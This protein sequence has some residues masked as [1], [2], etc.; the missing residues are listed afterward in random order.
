[1]NRKIDRVVVLLNRVDE[2]PAP[3]LN[4][5]PWTTCRPFVE[6]AVLVLWNERVNPIAC[7]RSITKTAKAKGVKKT[8]VVEQPLLGLRVQSAEHCSKANGAA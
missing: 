7:A 1:M 4:P 3:T 2:L 5:L 8:C 6:I